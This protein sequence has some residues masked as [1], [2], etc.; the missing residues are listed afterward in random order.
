VL[1]VEVGPV[2]VGPV[3]V[4]PVEV[5]LVE[6][7]PVEA[8][9]VGVGDGSSRYMTSAI[10]VA[11]MTRVTTMIA[12]RVMPLKGFFRGSFGG[13]SGCLGGSGCISRSP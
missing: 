12:T 10:V 13:G 2:E 4:G 9:P 6:I 8:G 7:G 3:E 11:T 5:G 1:P